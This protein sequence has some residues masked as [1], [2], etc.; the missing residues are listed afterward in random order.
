MPLLNG[1]LDLPK[2]PHCNV[3]RPGL[4]QVFNYASHHYDG[5]NQRFWK[6]YYCVRC[7]GLITAS[8]DTEFG[9]VVEMFPQAIQIADAIPE[10]AKS[11]LQQAHD[12][13]H[14]PAGAVMLAA[15]SIDA[16]LKNKSYKA[17]SLKAR[18]DQAATD[19]L[20]TSEMAKWAHNVRLDANEQRHADEAVPLP[21]AQDAKHSIDFAIA[22]GEFLYVLPSKVTKGLEE[23]APKK[24]K[25][26][27]PPSE[28]E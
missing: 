15:S 6:V 3:D 4:H 5:S 23:S 27:V 16:M 20:I 1:Q 2:C 9:L 12:S 13:R 22:L 24:E 11:Y 8:S 10:P 26:E 14:A 21:D 28:T 17:G 18:I 19:H 25:S 7:G